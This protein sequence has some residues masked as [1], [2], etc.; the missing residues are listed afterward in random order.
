MIHRLLPEPIAARL[1]ASLWS[2]RYADMARREIATSGQ[3]RPR[4]P[5]PLPPPPV[6]CPGPQFP[7]KWRHRRERA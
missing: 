6:R 5:V 1:P 7:P 2:E 3:A 4:T